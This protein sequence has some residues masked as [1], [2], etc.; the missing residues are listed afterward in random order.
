LDNYHQAYVLDEDATPYVGTLRPMQVCDPHIVHSAATRVTFDGVAHGSHALTVLL[1]G[2][3][4][5]SVNPP[6][7]ANVTFTVS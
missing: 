5:V 1:A 3:N 6:V 4:K 2:S 7:A